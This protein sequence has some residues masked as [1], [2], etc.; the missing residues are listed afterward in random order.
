MS[1][2]AAD[3]IDVPRLNLHGTGLDASGLPVRPR[4]SVGPADWL[5]AADTLSRLASMGERAGRVFTLENLNTQVDHPG[6]PF[7]RAADTLALVEAVDSPGLRMNVD[8]YHAQ[9]G[10][11]NLV[12]LVRRAL[13]W[14]GE[15]Q[16]TDVPAAVSRAPARSGTRPWPRCCASS[17]TTVSW[18]W[19][20]GRATSPPPRSMRSVRRSR[21]PGRDG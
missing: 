2:R 8:L 5:P 16:I 14:I 13:P 18:D 20:R 3:V 21:T 7:A 19:R 12:A 1:L 11:G 15:I 17:T 10:E 6:T 9:I 4:D